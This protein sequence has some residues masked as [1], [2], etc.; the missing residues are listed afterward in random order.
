MVMART[1]GKSKIEAQELD[2]EHELPPSD[3]QAENSTSTV[4][5]GT[6]QTPAATRDSEIEK[7]RSE[8]D[9]LLDRLARSQAEFDNA[10]KRAAVEQQ[11]FRDYALADAIKSLLPTLDSFERALKTSEEKSEFRNG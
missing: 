10:R 6:G 7:L 5:E 9:T 2:I 4:A 3:G 11:K 8:R 1:N